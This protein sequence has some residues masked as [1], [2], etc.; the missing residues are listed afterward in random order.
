[1]NDWL[2]GLAAGAVRPQAFEGLDENQ[3][4]ELGTVYGSMAAE[5]GWQA[6]MEHLELYRVQIGLFGHRDKEKRPGY[7][8]GFLDALEQL[9]AVVESTAEQAREILARRH[10]E[11]EQKALQERRKKLGLRVVEEGEDDG[12]Y[13]SSR[14]PVGGDEAGL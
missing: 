4:V 14:S 10:K 13:A 1:M 2:K 8:E 9:P 7:W 6:F 12:S 3:L 5:R 11:G